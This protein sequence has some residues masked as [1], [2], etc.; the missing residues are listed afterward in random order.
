M[1]R[2]AMAMSPWPV[3]S[4]TGRLRSRALSVA[5][6]VSPS[7]PGRR[8]S[9]MMMPAKS[10]P[11]RS[12]ASSALATPSLAI[13]SRAR[14]CWQPSSTWGSSS[15][16]ST[17]RLS[18]M[19]GDSW[20]WSAQ[21]QIQLEGGAA[22]VR[23]QNVQCTAGRGGQAGGQ[24]QGAAQAVLAGLGGEEGFEQVD[25]GV[26]RDAR[27]V[28]PHLQAVPCVGALGPA[29]QPELAVGLAGQGIQGVDDQVDQDLLQ[30]GLVD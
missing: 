17:L 13:S 30:A 19:G 8:I 6:R 11:T 27:A 7:M 5:S 28:V 12:R 4:T 21:R 2:T 14:A 24:G 22:L 23:V 25:P 16:I 18:F 20:R 15:T 1:A 26:R 9:L 3:I 29:V 10:S